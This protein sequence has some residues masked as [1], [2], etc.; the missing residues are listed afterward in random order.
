M[1]NLAIFLL[2][3]IVGGGAVLYPVVEDKVTRRTAPPRRR[4]RRDS[5]VRRCDPS[6]PASPFE[7]IALGQVARFDDATIERIKGRLQ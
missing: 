5:T 3:L 6:A 2:V 4:A 7:L 1:S